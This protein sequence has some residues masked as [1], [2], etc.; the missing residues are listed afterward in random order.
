MLT[1]A[2]EEDGRRYA[3]EGEMVTFTCQVIGSFSLQWDSPLISPI[4][5]T[6]NPVN[7][8]MSMSP[9]IA[10]LTST[11][12][13]GFNRN[14]IS[15]LQVTASRTF[16]RNDT[17]VQCRNQLRV[18]ESSRFTV[19][20]NNTEYCF[21]YLTENVY[22]THALTLNMCLCLFRAPDQFGAEIF[23]FCQ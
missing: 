10:T 11:T 18:N 15:T 20:G 3:C 9:F 16:A 12:G 6:S 23:F 2:V 8:M 14:F 19:A 7:T 5:F 21:I 4:I 17:T 1:S 22:S 13:S